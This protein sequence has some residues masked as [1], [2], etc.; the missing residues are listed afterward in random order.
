MEEK[1]AIV[2]SKDELK[3]AIELS[4]IFV[5]D[6]NDLKLNEALQEAGKILNNQAKMNVRGCKNIVFEKTVV[7]EK[8]N[9]SKEISQLKELGSLIEGILDNDKFILKSNNMEEALN[10]I[11]QLINLGKH[12]HV[13][14]EED[15]YKKKVIENLKREKAEISKA[16]KELERVIKEQLKPEIAKSQEDAKKIENIKS[17]LLNDF[18]VVQEHLRNFEQQTINVA[19]F[20]TKKSGKSMV[21][22]CLLGEEY[23]P[24]SLELPTPNIINYK[25][26]K[27]KYIKLKY[28]GDD[29]VFDNQ[30]KIK[31]YIEDEFD[32]AAKNG[33]RL[34][35]MLVEY[36]EKDGINYAILD[37]PGPDFYGSNH[38]ITEEI[39]KYEEVNVVV[40]L[41]DYSKYAQDSEI[42]LFEQ[43]SKKLK[44]MQSVDTIICL[45]NKIDLIFQDVDTEKIKLRVTDFIES[46]LKDFGFNKLII[47]PTSALMSFYANKLYEFF[48]EDLLN[49]E[50]MKLFLEKNYEKVEEK[51]PYKTYITIVENFAN[52]LKR[53]FKLKN[54]GFNEVLEFTGIETFKKYLQFIVTYKAELRLLWR[55]ISEIYSKLSSIIT[56]IENLGIEKAKREKENLEKE[57]RSLMKDVDE[58]IDS[59]IEIETIDKL[60]EEV[61]KVKEEYKTSIKT[62][63]KKFEDRFKSI[64]DGWGRE[65]STEF[66]GDVKKLEVGS[67]KKEKFEEDWKEKSLKLYDDATAFFNLV[68]NELQFDTIALKT[69]EEDFN[70]LL[71]KTADE[72]KGKIKKFEE[73][74]NKKYGFNTSI[75]IPNLRLE[76][77]FSP[78]EKIYSKIQ[79]KLVLS[80]KINT[81]KEFFE[82]RIR[83]RGGL[84][85]WIL[86]LLF[87]KNYNYK[88]EGLIEKFEEKIK[89]EISDAQSKFKNDLESIIQEGYNKLEEE[90]KDVSSKNEK[91]IEQFF[92]NIKES[93]ETLKEGFSLEFQTLESIID[94][95]KKVADNELATTKDIWSRVYKPYTDYNKQK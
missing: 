84:L 26:S 62:V 6:R 55:L 14:L 10:L 39:L 66:K 29:R 60:R 74:F 3:N 65:L 44:D 19:V 56:V 47:I 21:V 52:S 33:G 53:A 94:I 27:D 17:D 68:F 75:D 77:D 24:T 22:N 36:P 25:P 30:E 67:L 40:F 95:F 78:I 34:Q 5:L 31:K 70:K 80:L 90:L 37:T 91:Y 83:K 46:K 1:V 93:I 85:Q 41:M 28:K 63:V 59:K 7:Y 73:E 8:N 71:N 54:I 35:N 9:E 79:D 72:F 4:K 61:S 81:E 49:A 69:T 15:I 38:N 89:H 42:K 86:N 58:F 57:L 88:V 48:G 13:W 11:Q 64:L 23:A 87:G 32:K 82:N 45:V 92:K 43:L 51:E 50:D 20:A 76:V 16:I 12:P 2:K 18:S